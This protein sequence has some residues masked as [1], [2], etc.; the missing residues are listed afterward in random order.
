MSLLSWLRGLFAPKDP[1][2]NYVVAVMP[3]RESEYIF[4]CGTYNKSLHSWTR[5]LEYAKR[6]ESAADALNKAKDL[7]Y[8][9]WGVFDTRTYNTEEKIRQELSKL[10]G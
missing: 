6:F 3:L 7:D 2:P 1:N 9:C 8:S 4:Y 10:R 5:K